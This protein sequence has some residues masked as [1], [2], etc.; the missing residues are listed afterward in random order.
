MKTAADP[1]KVAVKAW[2]KKNAPTFEDKK[3]GEI[4]ATGLAE[5]AAEEFD[6]KDIGGWLDDETHWVWDLAA[7]VAEAAEKTGKTAAFAPGDRAIDT[8]VPGG[9]AVEIVSQRGDSYFT[10]VV[11]QWNGKA[12]GEMRN[13]P[14]RSLKP[15]KTANT[16][17]QWEKADKLITGSDPLIAGIRKN[18][19]A[20][21]AVAA[22]RRE[23]ARH[24]PPY[25]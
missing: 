17:D 14:A 3:T 1:S 20:A 25:R 22:V 8:R 18:A 23:E 15:Q 7:E 11:S 6:E 4:D 9:L 24:W 2:M 13:V 5:A 16:P 21:R 19:A 10:A 12:T